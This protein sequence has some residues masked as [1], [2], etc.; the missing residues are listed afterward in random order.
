MWGG[1]RR[2]EVLLCG[3]SIWLNTSTVSGCVLVHLSHSQCCPLEVCCYVSLGAIYLD[4]G[5]LHYRFCFLLLPFRGD[6]HTSEAQSTVAPLQVVC[7]SKPV[8]GPA[9]VL[10]SHALCIVLHNKLKHCILF[11]LYSSHA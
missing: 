1:G 11:L 6:E 3:R 10:V 4:S 9:H 2:M 8:T 5:Q 7:F